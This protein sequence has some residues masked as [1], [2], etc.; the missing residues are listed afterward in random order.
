MHVS[1]SFGDV[2]VKG[3]EYQ[4]LTFKTIS[5]MSS[6]TPSAVVTHADAFDLD[7]SCLS[8]IQRGQ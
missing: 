7:C 4:A 1:R 6:I 2:G 8:T 5:V 3:A